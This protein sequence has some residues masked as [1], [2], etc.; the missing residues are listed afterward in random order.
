MD[1]AITLPRFEFWLR[2]LLVM[3]LD[4]LPNLSEQ[5][6]LYLQMGNIKSKYQVMKQADLDSNV[7]HM[8]IQKKFILIN[9][10]KV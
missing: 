3:T 4:K 2:H 10:T 7:I 5:Q 8:N 6:L 9:N 1:S